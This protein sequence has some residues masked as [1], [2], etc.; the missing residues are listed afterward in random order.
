MIPV[1]TA[2]VCATF[3][4]AGAQSDYESYGTKTCAVMATVFFLVAHFNFSMNIFY[5]HRPYDYLNIGT[6]TLF[7]MGQM[8]MGVSALDEDTMFPKTHFRTV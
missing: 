5:L 2:L 8:L 7:S 4:R 3:W 6:L 1:H